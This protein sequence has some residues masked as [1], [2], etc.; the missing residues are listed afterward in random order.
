MLK[1]MGLRSIAES[2]LV[3]SIELDTFCIPLAAPQLLLVI[4]TSACGG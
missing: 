3:S 1:E 4:I 2:G